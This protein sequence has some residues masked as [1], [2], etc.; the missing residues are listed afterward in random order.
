MKYLSGLSLACGALLSTAAFTSASATTL[1]NVKAKGFLQC[2]VNVAV[3]GFSAPTPSGDWAGMD[4]DF[5][6]AVAAAVFGDATKVKY[7]PLSSAE[8][9]TAL[10]SGEIDL[11]SRNA[12]WTISRDTSLGLNFRPIT[13][14]DG[15]GFITHAGLGVTKA[16]ELSG[17]TICFQ[18]GT[19]VELVVADFFRGRNLEYKPLVFSKPEELIQAYEAGR[20]DAMSTDRS[21]LYSRRLELKD[22]SAHVILPDVISNEPLSPTVRQGDDQWLDIVSWT[23]YAMLNAEAYGITQA[24]VEEM[25]KSTKPEIMRIL[26][27]EPETKIGTDLGLT[28]DWAYNIIKA[29][30]NYGEAFERN[31]GQ[32]SPLKIERGQNALWTQ[33]GLQYAPPIR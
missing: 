32:G 6:K 31:L 4:I 2:G 16:D 20:C 21:E 7:T 13:Y 8:R 1:D 28:N 30:G 29:V 3:V 23:H 33:G 14:Y 26:G 12:T 18:T 17:A 19:T 5:C 25:R 27:T 9:F 24:N 22:P 15:L 10:Q 11:L